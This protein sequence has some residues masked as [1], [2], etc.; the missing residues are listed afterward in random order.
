MWGPRESDRGAWPGL[1]IVM[2]SKFLISS[3]YWSLKGPSEGGSTWSLSGEVIFHLKQLFYWDL[4]SKWKFW[5][6]IIWDK[7][8]CICQT[9]ALC[10]KRMVHCLITFSALWCCRLL[11]Q[12]SFP[13][14]HLYRALLRSIGDAICAWRRMVP[15]IMIL[16]AIRLSA[17]VS[18][19]KETNEL[20]RHL[21][22]RVQSFRFSVLDFVPVL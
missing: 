1:W 4:E 7:E 2:V 3:F 17:G 15:L 8:V 16:G 9:A 18:G 22:S 19:K 12:C 6:L 5:L 13:I 14:L 11:M 20:W 10:M 21:V